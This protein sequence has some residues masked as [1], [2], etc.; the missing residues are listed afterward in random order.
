MP[1]MQSGAAVTNAVLA[2]AFRSALAHQGLAAVAVLALLAVASAAIR[3]RWPAL[4]RPAGPASEPRGRPVLRTGFGLLWIL[5]GVLQAQPAM[6]AGLP[7]TVIAPVAASSP[8]WVQHLTNWAATGWSFHPV[9]A[10][11]AAVWIQV[12]IGLW[13]LGARRGLWSRAAGA[14]SVG[15]GLVVW[16]FGEAFGGIFAPGLSVLSGAPGAVLFYCLAG[17][18]VALPDRSWQSPALGR[19]VLGGLGLFLI[20]MAVLQAWPGRGFWSGTAAHGKPGALASMIASMDTTPQPAPIARLVTDFAVFAASHGFGVNLFAVIALAAIGAGLLAGNR[21][22]LGPVLVVM[23]VLCIADWVLIEDFGFFGGVGTDPNSMIPLLLVAVGGYLAVTCAPA[24]EPVTRMPASSLPSTCPPAANP[25]AVPGGSQP[26]PGGQQPPSGPDVRRS[27]PTLPEWAGP[28][29]LAS[30]FASARIPGVVASWAVALLILGG[31]PMAF[32]EAN[33]NADPIIATAMAG[34]PISLDYPAPSFAL[35][36]Q[37]GRLLSLASMRGKI[38]LL[39]FI[40]PISP[41]DGH[42]IAQEAKMADALL[43]RQSA[44]VELVAV[45]LSPGPL[46]DGYLAA[47]DE[48]ERLSGL[49]NWNFLTGPLGQLNEIWKQY[50]VFA[51]VPP[52]GGR[53]VHN[54]LAYVIDAAGQ[55]RT[56]LNDDPVPGTA[57]SQSSFA[58]EFAQVIEQAIG[59]R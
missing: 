21:R 58:V 56:E 29:R 10:G 12:G 59:S 2:A 19:R 35:T 24:T 44:A 15:W 54:D 34:P 7:G 18:L 11:A 53:V 36:D 38:V 33:P 51:G 16:T 30:A 8:R 22:L 26:L 14:V 31:T 40:D 4:V 6:P 13:L 28:R 5:D 57:S 17:C 46:S 50:H 20:G 43:G 37:G 39:L 52:D 3:Y 49:P 42:L 45:A 27:R 23:A 48:R 32:A 25:G 55:V 9:Q 41:S 1:G 47:F